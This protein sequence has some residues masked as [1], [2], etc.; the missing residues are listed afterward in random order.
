MIKRDVKYNLKTTVF[1]LI[2]VQLLILMYLPTMEMVMDQMEDF[3]GFLD[4][5]PNILKALANLEDEVFMTPEGYF[6]T[7]GMGF[8]YILSAV[9]GASLVSRTFA[10]EFSGKTYENLLVKPRSRKRIFLEKFGVVAF[11]EIIYALVFTAGLLVQYSIFIKE[12]YSVK[13]LIGFGIYIFVVAFLSSAMSFLLSLWKSTYQSVMVIMVMFTF[14][15]YFLEA[16][17]RAIQNMKWLS[18]ISIFSYIPTIDLIKTRSYN[19]V[20]ILV[21]LATG[22]GILV[23][24]YSIFNKKDLVY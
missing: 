15:S 1:W 8:M 23:A 6:G 24:A 19:F 21:L 13:V 11:Y 7:E 4:K 3:K 20:G 16:M 14:L 18:Y 12:P 22:C 9:F 17:G 2:A 5:L 10:R